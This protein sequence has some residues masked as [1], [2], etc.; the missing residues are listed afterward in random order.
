MLKMRTQADEKVVFGIYSRIAGKDFEVESTV[1]DSGSA[2]NII[3]FF[4]NESES[5]GISDCGVIPISF[6]GQ[7]FPPL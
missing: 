5:L 7:V 1:L 3:I 4:G 6:E 2:V